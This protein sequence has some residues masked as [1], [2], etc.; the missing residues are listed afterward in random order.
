M[1]MQKKRW[2]EFLRKEVPE[3]DFLE[4]FDSKR[5]FGFTKEHDGMF[6]FY[7]ANALDLFFEEFPVHERKQVI[8]LHALFK[9]IFLETTVDLALKGRHNCLTAQE[10]AEEVALMS[11]Q[12]FF[13]HCFQDPGLINAL[14]L[15]GIE[16]RL[17]L[18]VFRDF[19]RKNKGFNL[20]EFIEKKVNEL[21]NGKKEI[22][23]R[24]I[25]VLVQ[26]IVSSVTESF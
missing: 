5:L 25:R 24:E 22:S 13:Q 14:V 2:R 7:F 18:N 21:M 17:Q 12:I 11:K 20:H 6:E 9:K 4:E 23:F 10:F 8:K 1:V 16:E 15:A 26:E 3:I 19:L